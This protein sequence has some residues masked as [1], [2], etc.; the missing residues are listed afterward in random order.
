MIVLVCS[1]DIVLLCREAL[2]E[3]LR[4]ASEPVLKLWVSPACCLAR[5]TPM[6]R[7]DLSAPNW[8][9]RL[10][11]QFA[12]RIANIANHQR[13]EVLLGAILLHSAEGF[14]TQITRF[15]PA[16]TA[17]SLKPLAMRTSAEFTANFRPPPP[18]IYLLWPF[19]LTNPTEIREKTPKL[20]NC[21]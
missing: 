21:L 4:L 7:K 17:S 12:I 15:E 1:V 6:M 3:A 11:L 8:A 14:R 9:I 13:F 2:Q 18:K 16:F 5:E 20:P 10:W 19:G